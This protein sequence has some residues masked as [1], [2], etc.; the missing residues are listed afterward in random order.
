MSKKPIRNTIETTLSLLLWQQLSWSSVITKQHKFH[1]KIH[2]QKK[3]KIC[4]QK[5]KKIR[6]EK[7]K[8]QSNL[9][10]QFLWTNWHLPGICFSCDSQFS[11]Y[12]CWRWLWLHWSNLWHISQ[13][14]LRSR[15][16]D[17]TKIG[18]VKLLSSKECSDTIE[19]MREEL[20][21]QR[22]ILSN[23]CL[24]TNTAR[25]YLQLPLRQWGAG[26]VY[27]LVLSSWKVNIAENPIAVMGL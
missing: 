22:C 16:K 17:C 7:E 2:K 19:K 12:H 20:P 26:N 25:T 4:W 21:T 6:K 27:L 18:F 10:M 1:L 5:E 13:T 3:M 11:Q 24:V 15:E 23:F 14:R 9:E 8:I